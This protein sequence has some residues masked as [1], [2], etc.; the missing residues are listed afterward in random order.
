MSAPDMSVTDMSVIEAARPE[1]QIEAS[2]P[3]VNVFVSAHAGSGKTTTLVRR[4][5]RL[6][7]RGARPDTILCVTYTKAAAAEMQRRLFDLLGEWSVMDD[8]NLASGLA[9]I[10]EAMGADDLGRARRLFA[11]ALET[12]GGLKIQTIHAFCEKLLRKFPLEA[13]ISP[14][15]TVIDDVAADRLARSAREQ[16]ARLAAEKPDSVLGRAWAHFAVTL[17]H[18][19]FD[20]MFDLLAKRSKAIAAYVN[21]VAF[22]GL[23]ADVFT[24]VGLAAPITPEAIGEAAIAA[25]RWADWLDGAKALASSTGVK[26]Q[27]LGQAL[28]ALA[29]RGLSGGEIAFAQAC[30]LF[31][32]AD[33]KPLAS[34][35]S[36]SV[37]AHLRAWLK[38]EQERLCT[39]A[40]QVRA[41]VVAR[42]TF[43]ALS[44][45]AYSAAIYAAE[46]S[47]RGEL[48][49]ADLVETTRALLLEHADAAWVLYK[50]DRGIEHILLDE[51][52]DTAPEQWEIIRPLTDEFFAGAGGGRDGRTLFVVGDE[53]QSIYSFMG[54]APERLRL[55]AQNYRARIEA[56]GCPFVETPLRESF[57]STPE[58]LRL[59]DATF[60]DADSLRALTAGAGATALEHVA[61]RSA[62]SGCVELWPTLKDNKRTLTD[63]WVPLD[64]EAEA[65]A[66]KVLARR[67]AQEIARIIGDGDAVWSRTGQRPAGPG[68]VLILVRQRDALFDEIIRALKQHSIPVAGADK[69][70]LS[71]HIVFD[72]L[73]A[74]TR[75]C[76][77]PSDDLTLAALLRSP[78]CDLGEGDL[79]DLAVHRERTLWAELNRRA[80]ERQTWIRARN[81]LSW[82]RGRAFDRPPFEFL[83][84][85]LAYRDPEGRSMR[86]RLLTRLGQEAEDALD[87]ALNQVAAAE[88]R[89]IVDLERLVATLAGAEIAVKRESESAADRVRIMTVHGAKGLEAPI[90][91]LPDT[92]SSH[93][94]LDPLLERIGG[95]FLWAPT[96]GAD[97]NASK[98]A[99]LRACA[100]VEDER[101]RLLYVALTRAR[102]RLIVCGRVAANRKQAPDDCWHKLVERGFA[103]AAIAAEVRDIELAGEP[104]RRF[105]SDP[106]PLGRRRPTSDSADRLPAWAGVAPPREAKPTARAPSSLNAGKA[107]AASSPLSRA[108]GLG[109]FRRGDLIHKLLEILP[110]VAA[111]ERPS[112]AA[113]LLGRERDLDAA[114]RDEICAA[115]L[116]VLEDAR[117]APVFGEGS[118]A[119]VGIAGGAPELPAPISGR[120]DRLLVTPERVLVVDYKTDRPSPDR[121]EDADPAYLTQMAAYVAVLRQIFPDRRVEAALVWTDGPKLTPIPDAVIAASLAEL[122]KSG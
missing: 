60:A 74:L 53:K 6:L 110:E 57:R 32:T 8:L 56:A 72:D 113:R 106:T 77:D 55:E 122:G 68:D 36:V 85:T 73:L 3:G 28:Q 49:F 59:V 30:A 66:R 97:C 69:L 62:H 96:K 17:D 76:L 15:F 64:A 10:G 94:K 99:R 65:S 103:H 104:V 92:V 18:A 116:A 87:E 14:G 86:Q 41:A 42:E 39:A 20:A 109:R 119:E 47:A 107:V 105:G 54:A 67:I 71:E 91:I 102:D 1:P 16:V 48:D 35:G 115:A 26:D 23:E 82:A 4:V 33:D 84:Q 58:I 95:G 63:A 52:Q 13:D 83:A 81:F 21:D 19:A 38:Q 12:P 70:A 111:C 46:K 2:Q 31:C 117:F 24:G 114:Q 50:L 121:A 118:R 88:A 34:M 5:A 90:V 120:I 51:A 98:E 29:E 9:E 22:S 7:L 44:M 27:R 75:F 79:F 80:G 78:F 45:G 112:A 61:R 37:A 25:T 11:Q 40:E 101:R 89:T 100:K 108:A 43:L 93:V